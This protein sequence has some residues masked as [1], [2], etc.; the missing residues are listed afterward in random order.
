MPKQKNIPVGYKSSPLGII[1]EDWE[2]KNLGNLGNIIGGLTYSPENI[3]DDGV[4]VLRSSNIQEGQLAFDDNVHVSVKTGDFNPVKKGDILICVRNGS[5]S[6]I[7]KNAIITQ[8][9]EGLAFGA[10]MAVFRSGENKYLK[11]LFETN[12]YKREIHINLGATINSINGSD[13]KLFKFPIPSPREQTAIA[14][15]LST[16]DKAIQLTTQLIAQKE[17]RKKWLMQQLLSGKKRLKGFGEEKWEKIKL[18]KLIK[19]HK[20]KPTNKS[21]FEILTSAKTGLMKQNEYYGD[22]RITNREDVDYNV[23]PQNYLTYRS[24]SDDGLFTF[25]QNNLGFTGLIS[26]YYP[27]FQIE[28]GSAEFILYYLNYFKTKLT[29]F[30][31]GT[32][33]LVLS[34]EALKEAS[35]H[36]PK[37]DEQ[38]SITAI[39]KISDNDIQLLRDKVDLLKDQKKGLMQ[40][41]LTGKKRLKF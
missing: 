2:I 12:Y 33:Q 23:I 35:F 8:G 26:G 41:L 36:L 14:D 5:K 31:V 9:A 1:P 24:R 29:K 3:S 17:L 21:S 13:L 38:N 32:S 18:K 19:E 20:E 37:L 7:G 22:N 40:Q 15:L 6:L 16:W 25:N 30:S 4:L 34:I 27:V 28:N 39:L 10:F 11:H